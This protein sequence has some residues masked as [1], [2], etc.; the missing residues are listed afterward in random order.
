MSQRT[1]HKPKT[2]AQ[3]NWEKKQLIKRRNASPDAA[4]ELDQALEKVQSRLLAKIRKN[5]Q[6]FTGTV[7]KVA[8][9]LLDPDV[10]NRILDV[11]GTRHHNY[12][13]SQT[14]H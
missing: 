14:R 11:A 3:L 6:N 1:Q 13:Q 10:F 8:Q 12:I 7:V 9:E 2:M 4:A 5:D